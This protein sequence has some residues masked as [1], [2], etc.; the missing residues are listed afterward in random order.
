MTFRDTEG[1]ERDNAIRE[2]IRQYFSDPGGIQQVDAVCLVVQAPSARLTP[3]QRYI[4]KSILSIFGN[5]IKDNIRI[6]ATQPR[7]ARFDGHRRRQNGV[8]AGCQGQ[9][10][11]SQIQQFR[12]LPQRRQRPVQQFVL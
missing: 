5:D 6:M 11:L 1:L 12:L 4:F 7:A 9:A 8:P 10:V 3:I 2:Q